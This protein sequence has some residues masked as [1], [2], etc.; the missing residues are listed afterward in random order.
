V[1]PEDFTAIAP[2]FKIHGCMFDA[3]ADDKSNAHHIKF[4]RAILPLL[5]AADYVMRYNN[6][7]NNDRNDTDDNSI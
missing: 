3:D 1:D 2:R 4:M 7:D 6:N 5:D